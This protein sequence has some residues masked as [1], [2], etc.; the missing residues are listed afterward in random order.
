MKHFLLVAAFAFLFADTLRA[1]EW[2]DAVFAGYH[3][4]VYQMSLLR[5]CRHRY[6]HFIHFPGNA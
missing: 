5:R 6:D 3:R 4:H 1:S 2:A